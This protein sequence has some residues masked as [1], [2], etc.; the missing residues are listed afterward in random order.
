MGTIQQRRASDGATRFKA[1]VRLKGHPT[2][3][4]TFRRKTDAKKWIQQTE[5]AIREGRHFRTSQARKHTVAELIERYEREVLPH[6]PMADKQA[7]Q[8]R[9]WKSQLGSLSLADLT[10]SRIAEARDVLQAQKLSTGKVRAPATI[11]RFMAALSHV[12][13]VAVNEWEWLEANPMK[14]VRKPKES[15]GRIRYLSSDELSRLLDATRQS[16]HPYL[17]LW[18]VLAVSTGMRRGEILGLTWS[19]VS[20]EPGNECVVLEHTKNGERRY[21]PL[22]GPSLDIIKE[23]H[24]K[25]EGKVALVFPQVRPSRDGTRGGAATF[26]YKSWSK[27]VELAAIENFRFHDLRHTTASYLAMQGRSSSEIA[28]VLG[29]KTLQMVKRYAHIG[30]AHLR[31]VMADVAEARLGGV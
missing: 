19:E 29:H 18:T 27:A 17:H 2:E 26:S 4:A 28:A 13:T 31:N 30:N 24:A 9:F 23:L 10:P 20:L 11:V 6:K 16:D 1:V 22:V 3:T 12:F 8:L 25:R 14:R 21:V 15:S 5:A 7:P